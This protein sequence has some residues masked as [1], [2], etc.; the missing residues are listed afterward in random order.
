[1]VHRTEETG[2]MNAS[3]LMEKY[4]HSQGAL[5]YD[6]GR[7][8][9]AISFFEKAVA[10]DDQSYTRYHLCLAYAEK[11]DFAKALREINRAIELNPSV[12]KY[13]H[14]RGLIWESIGDRA[15][16][17][18]DQSRAT[19]LDANYTRIGEIRSSYSAIEQAFSN[20]DML[21]WCS[22]LRVKDR[23]LSRVVRGFEESLKKISEAVETASC[24]LPCPSYCCHFEGETVRH[25]VHIGAWKL[26]EIR[27][28]LKEKN[29]CEGD[30]LG[31]IPFTGEHLLRLVPP[32]Y[33]LKERD[34]KFVYYPKRSEGRLGK[35]DLSQIPK[36][37]DY[38][39]LLWIS[40]KSRACV[41]LCGGRCLIH[42]LGNESGLPACKEF[43]CMTGFVFA[44]LRHLE[45]VE[46]SQLQNMSMADL[47]RLGVEALLILH[48]TMYDD[49]LTRLK[50]SGYKALK[51]AVQADAMEESGEVQQYLAEYR[52][53]TAEYENLFATQREDAS[54]K[55]RN[56]L[57]GNAEKE[58]SEGGGKE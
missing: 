5:L 21:E 39:E 40:E 38:Q 10:L 30:F 54:G 33:V 42:D 41:F 9:A 22:T 37:K 14:R 4:L 51:A 2:G 7:F 46:T 23:E 50:N 26:S 49:H 55:I 12:A 28:F 52:R 31:R 17:A 56:R 36:A 58:K 53:L 25:G 32:H 11:K 57:K 20:V 34:E 16:A 18:E 45:I 47:N 8:D 3:G 19:K 1:M 15:R 27:R 24:L 43:L 13:Y 29:L 44:V 6:E 35:A 48:E